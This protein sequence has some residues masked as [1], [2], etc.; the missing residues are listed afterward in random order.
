MVKGRRRKKRGN[1]ASNSG[2]RGGDGSRKRCSSLKK[3]KFADVAREVRTCG[4]L[5]ECGGKKKSIET[6]G[7]KSW[8]GKTLGEIRKRKK[9]KGEKGPGSRKKGP[10]PGEVRL[11]GKSAAKKGDGVDDGERER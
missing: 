3:K 7:T 6:I 2:V 9:K 5:K 8:E 10:S 11:K 4:G 1:S